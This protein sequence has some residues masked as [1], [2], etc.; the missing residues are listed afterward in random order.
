VSSTRAPDRYRGALSPAEVAAAALVLQPF[1]GLCAVLVLLDPPTPAELAAAD[2]LVRALVMATS[3]WALPLTGAVAGVVWWRVGRPDADAAARAWRL[4]A[5]ASVVVVA[6]LA[7]VRVV[8][9]PA[10]PAVVPPEEGARPGIVLGLGAGILEEAVFR[11]GVL[12][13]LLLGT[14]RR[15]LAVILTSLAFALAHDLV[16]GAP[17]FSTAHFLARFLLPGMLMSS[18]CLWP[19]FAFV[20]ALHCGAHVLL[21]FLFR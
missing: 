19:G 18:L 15:V 11:L 17:A 3:P 8:G 10:L 21:P 12:P 7:S 6:V 16:P 2:P 4:A 1:V 13:M 5:M 14:R 9:G 20:F